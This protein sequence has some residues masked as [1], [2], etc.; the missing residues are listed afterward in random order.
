MINMRLNKIIHAPVITEKSLAD[1][2]A[3]NNFTFKVN[4][5]ASKGAIADAVKELFGVDVLNVRTMVM[6]GK[7]KRL[8]RTH[9]FTKSSAWK[10]AVVTIKEGQKIE[11]FPEG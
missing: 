5:K 2:A 10:K 3:L 8:R 6:P 11:L 7:P 1:K 4:R 9:L